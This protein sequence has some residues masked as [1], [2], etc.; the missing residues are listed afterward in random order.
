MLLV[1]GVG[2]HGDGPRTQPGQQLSEARVRGL[3]AA[4]AL[5][6]QA[7]GAQRAD[8]HANDGVGQQAALGGL[9]G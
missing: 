1:G 6:A 5:V 9:D 2:V 3:A 4:P 8:A 7:L